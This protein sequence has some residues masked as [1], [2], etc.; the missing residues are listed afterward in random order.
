ML[1]PLFGR[2]GG[3]LCIVK[4][5]GNM[6]T[7]QQNN[8]ANRPEPAE[9]TLLSAIEKI[10]NC[11]I[12][13]KLGD[14]FYTLMEQPLT[15]IARRM[16]IT[17]E[18][19]LVFALFMEQCSY[20]HI[21]ISDFSDMIGCRTIRIVAMM[22]EADKLS[23]RGFIC[24]HKDVDEI[25][26]NV[27]L[28][29]VEAVKE[30]RVFT[31]KP[32]AGLISSEFVDRLDS[33]FESGHNNEWALQDD[34]DF[35]I[36]SNS[37]LP[38]CQAVRKYGLDYHFSSLM[39]CMFA[40]RLLNYDDDMVCEGDWKGYFASKSILR[41]IRAELKNGTYPLRRHNLIEPRNNDGLGDPHYYHL[42]DAA[43]QELFPDMDLCAK[44]SEASRELVSHTTFAAKQLFYNPTVQGQID[45]LTALLMPERFKAIQSRMAES[46]MRQGFA[47]LFYGAPGTGKTETVNQLSRLTG[48]DV[49]M[50]DVSKIKSCW[51]GESEK[52]IKAAFDRYRKYVEKCE[53]APILLFNEADAVLGIRTEGAERAVDKMENSIQNIILQEM[54]QLNGIMI[55]TTNLTRNLDK[56]FE[57]RFIYKIEFERPSVEAKQAIWRT[58]IPSLD[59]P[60]A[61][62]LAE[63]YDFSGGQIENIARKRTV[64]LILNGTEPSVERLHAFCR[65][66]QLSDKPAV[67]RR[68]GF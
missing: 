23:K 14:D 35:L 46:G 50:I 64:D 62:T 29:V 49:M 61:H 25:Y 31:P 1:M 4:M 30:N 8:C 5:E 34:L 17:A 19:A 32:I 18:Q 63:C 7:N 38:F 11:A 45:Q 10:V 56:A 27:P 42:T 47:C 67:R 68:L 13:K 3:D 59:E 24:R 57:R 33:I 44:Q 15:Y 53:V 51:V 58:M 20:S 36:E 40:N 66:E 16:E 12:E 48:R 9:M 55:A 52:N 26:Y 54:E 2:G 43:K 60:T 41:N 6:E 21:Q 39:L 28:D 22:S 65:A 37:Q